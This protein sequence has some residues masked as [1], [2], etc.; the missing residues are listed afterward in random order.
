MMM[1]MSGSH[2]AIFPNMQKLDLPNGYYELPKGKLANV[3]TFL[4]M[5]APP[6]RALQ[7]FPAEVRLERVD[8]SDLSGYRQYFRAVGEDL[9][10]FSRL[11]MDDA[12]L[13]GI[14]KN[15]EVDSYLLMRGNEFCGLLE[16]DFSPKPECE[17]AFF[18]LKKGL[19]GQGLGRALMDEGLRQAWAKPI[20]RLFVHTCTLDSP[21]A[22]PFYIRSGFKP[23][24]VSIE[25]HDDPRLNGKL[26]MTACPQAPLVT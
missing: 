3:V 25:I 15:P 20:K 16:L 17:L 24:S 22:L 4:D 14:L 2:R 13:E 7:P 21:Q 1:G 23:V 19:I 11:I 10:W 5:T 26:P 6:A 12:K 18:G 9:M 8:P